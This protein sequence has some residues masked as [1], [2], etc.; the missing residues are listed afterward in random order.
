MNKQEEQEVKASPGSSLTCHK[1]S[2][3]QQAAAAA[4][5]FAR[6]LLVEVDKYS[7]A[8]PWFIPLATNV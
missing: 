6:L 3:A 1:L 7:A 5:R 8:I 4:H 2:P